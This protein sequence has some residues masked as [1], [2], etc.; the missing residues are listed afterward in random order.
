MATM[1][2]IFEPPLRLFA[3]QEPDSSELY[4][5][6]SILK[7]HW[8]PESYD[9]RLYLYT[10]RISHICLVENPEEAEFFLLPRAWNDYV[11]SGAVGEAVAFAKHAEHL[12]KLVI[13]WQAGD[14]EARI[15]IT[16]A[17]LIHS[18]LHRS[19]PRKPAYVLAR[20]AF[21]D[22]YTKSFPSDQPK[23]R[24]KS[25]KP[26]VGFCGHVSQGLTLRNM[27]QTG[28]SMLL[29]AA[30]QL[31]YGNYQPP[32]IY[33]PTLLRKQV[34]DA[35]TA[36]PEIE[37]RFILRDKYLGGN[38]PSAGTQQEFIDNLRN[39]DYTVCVR[40]NGNFSKRF[41]ETL[42]CGR[43]PI[44]ID[45]DCVLPF[46][47]AIDWRKYCVYIDQ[48]EVAHCAEKVADFHQDIHPDDFAALQQSCRDLWYEWLST[49][50]FYKHLSALRTLV[51]TDPH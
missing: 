44:F 50:G 47:F 21:N 7:A 26:I 6:L 34:L 8:G 11:S 31:G 29:H 46:D 5:Y 13:I 51:G 22:D 12:G 45:T 40:G 41:Y 30:Y 23:Y 3:G 19:R 38:N 17:I 15:P 18:G 36:S 16:N 10:T 33:P 32:P 49:D 42:C 4:R 27:L 25:P 24:Q 48:S 28:R 20:P 37:T 43:I 14:H 35:L 9:E 2:E 1:S 39:T